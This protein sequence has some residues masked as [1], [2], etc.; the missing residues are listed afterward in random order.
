MKLDAKDYERKMQKS[1][2]A[3][4]QLL[5][6][7][8]AGRANPEI[9]HRVTV[10][11]YG[12]PTAINQMAEVKMTDART[13]VIQ[14]WDGSTLKNIEKAILA[15]DIGINPQSDGKTIRMVFPQPT[16]ERRLELKKQVAKMGEEAKVAIRNLRRDA[17]DACK[18][19]KKKGEMTE[20]EMKASEKAVQDL[21][22]KYIKQIDD[23]TAKKNKE[24][25]DI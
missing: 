21:T 2:D 1:I 9:L 12:V 13:L 22:D 10:D 15:S 4:V 11:Y 7:I 20:D 6:T 16:E 3:Y 24:I 18:D 23:I 17:N 19:H 14:P 5:V 25:M 8:R